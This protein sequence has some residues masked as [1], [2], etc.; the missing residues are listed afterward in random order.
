LQLNAALFWLNRDDVQVATSIVRVRDDNSAEFIDFVSNAASGTNYGAELDAQLYLNDQWAIFASVGFL[1][2]EINDFINAAG[3]DLDGRDQSQA[4]GYQ[5][6]IATEYS[7]TA[8]W[9]VRVEVEGKDDYFLS[10]SHSERAPGY[11]LVNATIGYNTE[12]WQVKLWARNLTDKDVV[13]RGFFFGNDP[14]DGFTARGFNQLGEPRNYGL[15]L[16]MSF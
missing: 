2:T 16:G 4:P 8:N 7:P 15:S 9:F 13:T 10:D 11:E 14:R 3:V 6:L 12:R 1:Q 5:F